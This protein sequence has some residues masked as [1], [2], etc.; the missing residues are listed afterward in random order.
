ML[1]RGLFDFALMVSI[2][3]LGT[4]RSPTAEGDS[5]LSLPVG[6]VAPLVF[7]SPIFIYGVWLLRGVGK[8]NRGEP[9]SPERGGTED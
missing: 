8:L 4:S 5:S 6:F 2:V 1:I 9:S 7:I 3:A